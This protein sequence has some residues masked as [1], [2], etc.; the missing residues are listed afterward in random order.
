LRWGISIQALIRRA[1][2]LAI[3]NEDQYK[4]LNKKVSAKGWK[5]EEPE[6]LNIPVEK[7]RGLSKLAEL[8]YGNPIDYKKFSQ[9]T[10]LSSS[11]LKEILLAH[12]TTQTNELN[13]QPKKPGNIKYLNFN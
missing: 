13:T 6:N 3:I 12:K 9:D 8:I 11:F 4:Y 5:K 7:P 10:K 2:D 1:K